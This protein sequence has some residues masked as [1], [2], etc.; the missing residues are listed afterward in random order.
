MRDPSTGTVRDA[1][2]LDGEM[3]YWILCF[4]IEPILTWLSDHPI[5][6]VPE[7]DQALD[8]ISRGS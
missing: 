2:K 1:V 3:G 8:Q 5:H 4:Y 7:L 6:P